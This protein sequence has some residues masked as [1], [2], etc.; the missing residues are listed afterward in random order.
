MGCRYSD[1]ET[2]KC[3]RFDPEVDQN[4]CDEN[5]FCI[6]EEDDCPLGVCEDFNCEDCHN[7]DNCE[8]RVRYEEE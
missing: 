2:G 8:D 3:A 5:G 1:F 6:C 7:Y 4:G